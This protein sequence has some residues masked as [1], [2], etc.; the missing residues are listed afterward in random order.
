MRYLP[1]V[2]L[3]YLILL[4][5]Q[6]SVYSQISK[7]EKKFWKNKAKMYVKNPLSLK[8]EFENYQEQIKDLKTRNKDLMQK[9]SGGGGQS[10][11]V[12]DSLRWALVQAEAELEALKSKNL[13]LESA[14][15]GQKKVNDMAIQPGLVYRVQI[16]AYVFYEMDNP[17]VNA[18]DFVAERADGFNK[19]VIGSYRT[20]EEAGEFKDEIRKMGIKDAW[21]VPYNDGVRVTIEEANTYLGNQ[22]KTSLL[23]N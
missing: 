8:G 12:V 18:G 21:V 23:N 3:L 11:E 19:Y 2:T 9:G 20:Y 1:V 16:G 7:E 10:S 15:A 14:Y 22:G 17:P 13:K 6:T 5:A 4:F